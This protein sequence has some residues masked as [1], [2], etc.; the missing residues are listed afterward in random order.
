MDTWVWNSR[1]QSLKGVC[2]DFFIPKIIFFSFHL[3]RIEKDE[4]KISKNFCVWYGTLNFEWE[5]KVWRNF[6]HSVSK[7]EEI[8]KFSK[9]VIFSKFEFKTNST[10]FLKRLLYSWI[11]SAFQSESPVWLDYQLYCIPPYVSVNSSK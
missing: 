8:A 11:N 1:R 6:T 4:R 2:Q 10:W 7:E 5:T 9:S 3:S